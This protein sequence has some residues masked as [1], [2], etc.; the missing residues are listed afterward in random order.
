MDNNKKQ[1]WL[2]LFFAIVMIFGMLVG[3]NLHKHTTSSNFFSSGKTNSIQEVVSLI[4]NKY[5]DKIK[6]DSISEATIN[7]LLSHLDP[8]SIYIPQND[9]QAIN[10]DLIGNF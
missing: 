1:I 4:Q 5:V 7:D 10:D 2:P 8:H 9:V 6:I 3:Y